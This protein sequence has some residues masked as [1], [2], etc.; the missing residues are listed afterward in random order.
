MKYE[1][2][3][4]KR[5]LNIDKHK[6]NFRD[7]PLV[8]KNPHVVLSSKY[9]SEKRFLAVSLIETF[10]VTVVYTYRGEN[11]RIISFGRARDENNKISRAIQKRNF[12]NLKVILIL[13]LPV[14]C[15]RRTLT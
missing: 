15:L 12:L 6:L 13:K 9:V 5:F 10:Y 3:E 1:R 8:F 2:D 11:I 4:D 7:V 14:Q